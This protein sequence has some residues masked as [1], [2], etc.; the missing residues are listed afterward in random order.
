M[1]AASTSASSSVSMGR[2]HPGRV[3]RSPVGQP[4]RGS[5]FC[6]DARRREDVAL[7]RHVTWATLDAGR[8]TLD[9]TWATL[10]A[11]RATLDAG[12]ST[13][14]ATWATLD[15]TWATLDAGRT[16]LDAT[17]A[18]LDAAWATLDATWATLDATWATL[19][20]AW[21]TCSTLRG[22]RSSATWATPGRHV[23]ATLADYVSDARDQVASISLRRHPPPPPRGTAPARLSATGALPGVSAV[24]PDPDQSHLQ[25][26]AAHPDAPK[27]PG[28]ACDRAILTGRRE[29]PR[30]GRRR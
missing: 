14:D 29:P 4:R 16:T 6:S 2:P 13:L 8:T 5:G 25:G 30:S 11:G 27:T 19:D 3:A 24:L 20:A 28:S 15:A 18:T 1:P 21:A 26:T 22:R 7:T 9:A 12:R 10:D 17:W 23:R